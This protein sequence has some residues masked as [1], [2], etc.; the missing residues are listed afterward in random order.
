MAKAL[1]GN[2]L[3][4]MFRA[5]TR[6]QTLFLVAK[7]HLKYNY[8]P[9]EE[10]KEIWKSM[11]DH[12]D[13]T[14]RLTTTGIL[15][16]EFV[17]NRKVIKVLS[18]IRK[19]DEINELDAV[20]QLEKFI[21]EKMFIEVY[22]KLPEL[23]N[24]ND[25]QGA[26]T[27][28]FEASEKLSQFTLKS[29]QYYTKIYK[30][31]LKRHDQRLLDKE[32]EDASGKGIGKVPTGIKP[33]DDLLLGGIAKGNAMLIMAASGVGKSKM[34]KFAGVSASRRGFRVLHI[35]GEGTEKEARDAYD[36]AIMGVNTHRLKYHTLSLKDRTELDKAV[37]QI[38]HF[39]G[40]IY[41]KAYEQFGAATYRDIRDYVV[42]ITEKEGPIDLLIVDYLE[43]F[44]PGNGKKYSTSNEGE[45]ARRL[46][47]AELFTNI[48]VEFNIAG[49]IP[50]QANDI[51][52]LLFNDATFQLTRHNI[53]EAKAVVR[54]FPYF[55]TLNQSID[56]KRERVLRLYV[57]KARFVDQSAEPV[58][59]ICTNYDVDRFYDHIS[60]VTKFGYEF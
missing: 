1:T 36:A 7:D 9:S 2:F 13:M 24:K 22:D 35:Q 51:A 49:I 27:L 33:L 57:D 34:A 29:G 56:E 38:Q 43:L 6:K 42:D 54:P 40:E 31:L 19:S 45:R 30:D 32:N 8:L 39:D 47:C 20:E 58:I 28:M 50:T 59:H 60:T 52:P 55:V 53:S 41:L 4:E 46:A 37:N 11:C 15:A 17:D 21:K 26:F 18:A 23:Y 10:Y 25:K 16:E 48:C 5:C 14:T 12:F 44:D 3:N